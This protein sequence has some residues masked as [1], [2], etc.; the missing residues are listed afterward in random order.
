M[1]EDLKKELPVYLSKAAD[2]DRNAD[3]VEWWKD[4][5]DDLPFWSA[6]AGKIFLVQPSSA[7]AERVFSLLQKFLW[8]LTYGLF[9]IFYNVAV[10]QEITT[11]VCVFVYISHNSFFT[12]HNWILFKHNDKI[13]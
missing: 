13:F 5:S 3:P 11:S 4:H 8:F 2:L 12:K 1:L 7:S 6:A 9:A 10:Q